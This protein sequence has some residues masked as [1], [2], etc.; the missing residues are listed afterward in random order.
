VAYVDVDVF[1]GIPEKRVET[2][3]E[4]NEQVTMRRLLTPQEITDEVK[5]LLNESKSDPSQPQKRRLG[6]NVADVEGGVIHPTQLALLSP[7]VPDTLIL[8]R[9]EP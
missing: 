9:I 5:N 1:G 6:I 7:Q 8:N 3:T 4:G 2:I